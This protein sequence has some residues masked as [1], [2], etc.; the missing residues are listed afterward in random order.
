MKRIEHKH[1]VW[2]VGVGLLTVGCQSARDSFTPLRE[3]E[4]MQRYERD[5]G[6]N[7]GPPSPWDRERHDQEMRWFEDAAKA[8]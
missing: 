5:P 8:K 4:A 2:V 6:L 3:A 1:W 7:P